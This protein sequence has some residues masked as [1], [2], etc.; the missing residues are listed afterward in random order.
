MLIASNL[1]GIVCA[2]RAAGEITP[3][4]FEA[5][6]KDNT[7]GLLTW[8]QPRGRSDAFPGHRVIV[9][10]FLC[11]K[12]SDGGDAWYREPGQ[13]TLQ[14]IEFTRMQV[15]PVKTKGSA[16][17]DMV[18]L[19]GKE[20][21]FDEKLLLGPRPLADVPI[22]V[23][24]VRAVGDTLILCFF[25]IAQHLQYD[26]AILDAAVPLSGNEQRRRVPKGQPIF[27]YGDERRERSNKLLRNYGR[28]GFQEF[29]ALMTRLG[30]FRESELGL[31]FPSMAAAVRDVPLNELADAVQHRQ[32]MVKPR[33]EQSFKNLVQEDIALAI[34]VLL[35]QP[36]M[37]KVEPV[38]EVKQP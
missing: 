6:V 3:S 17:V 31:Q 16:A 14:M 24:H 4:T 5:S 29:P 26:V 7:V 10:E 9:L 15:K 30:C 18:Y 34:P 37:V 33:L 19:Y 35:E 12:S 22:T 28:F 38:E 13:S 25:A 8:A 1:P 2:A 36:V 27:R 32:N 21:E 23:K 11:A 20:P